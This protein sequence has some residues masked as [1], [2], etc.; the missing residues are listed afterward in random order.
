MNRDIAEILALQALAFVVGD[1]K[2][3]NTFLTQTGLTADEMRAAAATVDFQ[4]GLLDFLAHHEDLL[5][6]FC[7]S[8]GLDPEDPARAHQALAPQRAE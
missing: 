8:Q 1:E 3:R 2:A 4:A 7:E 6:A 5:V